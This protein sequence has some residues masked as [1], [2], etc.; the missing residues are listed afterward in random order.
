MWF[1]LICFVVESSFFW[2]EKI[3]QR[4]LEEATAKSEL[5]DIAFRACM[6]SLFLFFDQEDGLHDIGQYIS[7]GRS[8][9][10]MR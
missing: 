4:E 9:R 7:L 8:P 1:Y 10:I 5:H 6:L 2:I 3:G